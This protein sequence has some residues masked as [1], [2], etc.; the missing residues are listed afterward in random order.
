VCVRQETR[1][2]ANVSG[3]SVFASPFFPEYPIFNHPTSVTICL[4]NHPHL[5]YTSYV[6][7]FTLPLAREF[8]G[9]VAWT[10]IA[11]VSHTRQLPGEFQSTNHGF[12][13]PIRHSHPSWFFRQL[14][15]SSSDSPDSTAHTSKQN[16][17]PLS[18]EKRS[19]LIIIAFLSDAFPPGFPAEFSTHVSQFISHF[20]TFRQSRIPFRVNHN[21]VR[22]KLQ[23]DY[24]AWKTMHQRY[25]TSPLF[26][27]LLVTISADVLYL[28]VYLVFMFLFVLTSIVP[29][30]Y[31]GAG[32]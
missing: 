10:L 32:T 4:Q 5:N 6:S 28:V 23:L 24:C 2:S 13:A 11:L 19:Y 20:S 22:D 8:L 17:T 18:N 31:E 27:I 16:P 15:D 30:P 25:H 14:K 21:I 29:A 3:D 7:E 26:Y 9:N 1:V 12:M